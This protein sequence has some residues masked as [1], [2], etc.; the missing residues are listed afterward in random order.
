MKIA[1]LINETF[2]I[3]VYPDEFR[4]SPVTDMYA[5]QFPVVI[6]GQVQQVPMNLIDIQFE[7]FAGKYA[8][9][10]VIEDPETGESVV[11][12]QLVAFGAP[13]LFDSGKRAIPYGLFL[14]IEEYRNEPTEGKLQAINANVTQF[15]FENSL[16]GFVLQVSEIR[17]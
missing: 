11:G 13:V 14:A 5:G 16:E 12:K 6:D 2:S 7:I 17:Q 15:T 8:R 10:T 3:E 4:Y 9:A 1:K